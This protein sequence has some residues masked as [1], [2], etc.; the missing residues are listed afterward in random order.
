MFSD[1]QQLYTSLEFDR[2]LD[3]IAGYSSSEL[4]K[5]RVLEIE[6]ISDIN[7]LQPR[8]NQVSQMMDLLRYDDPFPIHGIQDI[9]EPLSKTQLE[10][11]ILNID[12]LISIGKTL[13]VSQAVFRFLGSRQSKYSA[14]VSF[15][16][17]LKSFVEITREITK[18]I[19]YSTKEIKDNASKELTHIRR[20][21]RREQEKVRK[22]L[23]EIVEKS[24]DLLQEPIITIR[25]GRMVVPLREDC[26]GQLNGLI[27]DRSS[28]GATLFIEPMVVFEMNNQI[29]EMQIEERREI[30]R[31]L[32]ELT[33]LIR[34]HLEEITI[35]FE[36]LCELDALYAVAKFGVTWNCSVPKYNPQTLEIISGYHPLLLIKNED[37]DKV[38]PLNVQLDEKT[39]LLIIT[40]PNAGGK[41]VSLKTIGLLALMFQSGL[42][43]M[44][45]EM[46]QFPMFN[47]IFVDIGDLQ[48]LE[49]DLSTFSAHVGR[50]A[51]IL[52]NSTNQS[53]VLID[54]IGTGTDPT[55]GSALAMSFLQ[56]LH[57][58]KTFTV[59]TTHQ[60]ALKAYAHKLDGADNASM[61]F[62][63]KTLQPTYQFRIGI[64]GSSYAFE[65]ARRLG[66]PEEI[67]NDAKKSVGD[68]HGKL[69]EFILELEEKLNH[70]QQ[71]LSEADIKKAE[72][73]GLT[74]LYR[75][76]NAE[77]QKEE[78]KIK[79]KAVEESKAILDKANRVI[80]EAVKEIRTNQAA[81]QSIKNART[82][83]ESVK[84][85]VEEQL[86][87]FVEPE[88]TSTET[89]KNGD[90]AIW[91]DMNITGRIVS[92]PDANGNVWLEA[93]DLKLSLPINSLKLVKE[94]KKKQK[95]GKF[96]SSVQSTETL[97]TEI[98]LRGMTM[99][100]AQPVI[101]KYL[102][103]AY[104]YGLN[105][106]RII[107]G[108]GTGALRKK[109]NDYLKSHPKVEN[110][111]FGAWN[112]G[113]L[114][115]TVV[116]FKTN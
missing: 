49:Q 39:H 64:P 8:L 79:R 65:I 85:E 47:E 32:R 16:R 17:N 77:L 111:Q 69:E 23:S 68:S 22:R 31:L 116:K 102:D 21:L 74:K 42:P 82:K 24:K 7:L 96:K 48:S 91:K 30:E 44:A 99:D 108:K 12:L 104:L 101:E 114:G 63:S 70:Y 27:H 51:E 50:L 45:N 83:V 95:T 35:S 55:E 41:T 73:E 112:E 86:K 19:D 107:H 1:L 90:L 72:L 18:I 6:P 59:V 38:I 28:S 92:D 46:S 43:V 2:V 110:T 87:E 36:T 66:I 53:L 4:G 20:T 56:K 93:G 61:A 25:E 15:F 54:E 11:S 75:E 5:E 33:D 98:D 9:R 3:K 13:G 58:S 76:R 80:E 97:R 60:G 94:K 106:V 89:P 52:K 105:Q 62:D 103:Q 84:D 88:E 34:N 81:K 26:K 40:G 71:L 10:G 57:L 29:R 67:V 14:L 113:D 37:K 78:K 100:E 109:V 115:V